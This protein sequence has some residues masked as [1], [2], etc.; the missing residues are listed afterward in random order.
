[1]SGRLRS[2]FCLSL[3]LACVQAQAGLFD[4]DE[5]RRRV[6]ALR[7]EV[8]QHAS[9]L[10]DTTS[11]AQ[12]AARSQLELANQIE[13]LRAEV[14]QV[15]GQ[16]EVLGFEINSAQ[17]RQKDFY[18]DLD[19]RLR[20]LEGL[21][22]NGATAATSTNPAEAAATTATPGNASQSAPADP[23]REI[24]V[25][26][27]AL[28]LFKAG[29][30]QDAQAAFDDF[31]RSHGNSQLL[32]SAHYWA[33][34]ARYQQRDY[35]GAAEAYAQV[36]SRWPNDAKAA[37]ALLGQANSQRDLGNGAAMRKTLELLVAKYPTSNAAQQARTRLGAKQG[38]K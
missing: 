25:Y 2:L 7:Q 12:T 33:A 34:T 35:K 30:Y 5:A 10:A 9:Q 11:A 37:D 1:M 27:A 18:I 16:V 38:K 24:A 8:S 4:D 6:E 32:P 17:Q 21:A 36:A 20:K 31:S 14:A 23:T 19:S 28:N 22:E 29:R 13:Q 3:T 15:R 26:E